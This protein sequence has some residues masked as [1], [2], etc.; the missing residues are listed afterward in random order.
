MQ[1]PSISVVIRTRNERSRLEELLAALAAQEYAA[2]R[3]VVVVD[4]ASTDG[5]ADMARSRGAKV[6]N[7]PRDDF[8]YP[9]SMNLGVEHST[10]ELVALTVGHALPFRKDWLA[11]G[12]AHFAEPQVAGVFGPPLA[13]KDAT[14]AEKLFYLGGYLRA[15]FHGPHYAVPENWAGI[16]GATNC[17]LR[18]S[19][20]QEHPFDLR[21]ELGG[22]DIEWANWAIRKGWKIVCDHGFSLRHSHGNDWAGLKKQIAYWKSLG[23]PQKF[24]REA[25]RFR[26]DMKLDD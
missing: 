11:A 12:A 1:L 16:M 8:T 19:L 25:L 23:T 13:R 22:E 26:N 18:R 3:E 10:G 5:S 21:Y 7:I 14:L 15:R 2:A 6:F 24:D 4:N 20:W 9:R 17:M